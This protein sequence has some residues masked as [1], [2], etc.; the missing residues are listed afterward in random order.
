MANAKN[1]II[2]LSGQPATGK[3]TVKNILIQKYKEM[4][5]EVKEFA[6]GDKFREYFSD[7]VE[8]LIAVKNKDSE[9]CN[10][11]SQK[12]GIRKIM[13]TSDGSLKQESVKMIKETLDIMEERNFDFN[14]FDI[15]KANNSK[16]LSKIRKQIDL[17]IDRYIKEDLRNQINSSEKPNEIWI[18]DSRLAWNNIPED[19]SFSVRL[20][21]EEKVAGERAYKRFLQNFDNFVEMI[22]KS[23]ILNAINLKDK[24]LEINEKSK[25]EMNDEQKLQSKFDILE[26]II[27]TCSDIKLKNQYFKKLLGIKEESY[28]NLD[29][30]IEK[31]AARKQGENE[32]Y[33]ERYQVDLDDENNYKLIVDTSNLTPEEEA[34]MIVE[35]EQKSY[36]RNGYMVPE[37][38]KNIKD[39]DDID[40]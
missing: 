10:Q 39:N 23:H 6:T 36:T 1:R 26:T 38:N 14:S 24:L 16:S 30:A 31:I 11:L 18:I 19:E 37:I 4:G 3:S 17:V 33:K 2:T 27:N 22:S 5:F 32:R 29:I 28:E 35:A 40:R 9:K 7:M 20:I 21:S 8:L 15:E 12:E 13:Y 25:D 34:E